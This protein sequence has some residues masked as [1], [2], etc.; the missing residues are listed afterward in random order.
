MPAAEQAASRHIARILSNDS[1]ISIAW[2]GQV[3]GCITI[4]VVKQLEK[5]L[6][7]K[8]LIIWAVLFLLKM[9]KTK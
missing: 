4:P 9:N 2:K 1:R 7:R 8:A 6:I 5:R 3:A